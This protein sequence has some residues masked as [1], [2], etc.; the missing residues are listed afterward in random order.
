MTHIIASGKH[1]RK[2]EDGEMRVYRA[3]DCITPTEQELKNF[4]DRFVPSA[5]TLA[6]V[7]KAAKAEAAT[8]EAEATGTKAK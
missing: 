4:P 8:A 6:K 2:G 5:E 3:G 7:K 1:F